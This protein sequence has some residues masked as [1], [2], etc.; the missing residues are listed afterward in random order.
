MTKQKIK[1][2]ERFFDVLEKTKIRIERRD[3]M[4]E[5]LIKEIKEK[6]ESEDYINALYEVVVERDYDY[7][8]NLFPTKEDFKDFIEKYKDDCKCGVKN[9]NNI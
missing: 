8:E 3:K 5:K 7:I 4:K 1:Q 9:E 6:I 2:W